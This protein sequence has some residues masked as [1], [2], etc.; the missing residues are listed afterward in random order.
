M[1]FLR[2]ALEAEEPCCIS[3]VNCDLKVACGVK[4]SKLFS[5]FN[6]RVGFADYVNHFITFEDDLKAPAFSLFFE[7]FVGD[8]DDNILKMIDKQYLAF[9]PAIAE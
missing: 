8:I 9:H 4:K 1:R 6:I 3:F 5:L 2:E 7:L